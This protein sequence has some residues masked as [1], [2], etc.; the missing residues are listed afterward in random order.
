[1][2]VRTVQFGDGYSQAI[3]D[4]LNIKTQNW[5]LTFEGGLAY[6][7]PIRDFL[8][9]HAGSKS[10]TWIPPGE[11]SPLYFRASEWT[12]TS[13]GGGVYQITVEFK[14]VFHT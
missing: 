12:M 6:V 9:R 10:F 1:M 7:K 13:V 8:D 2:R 14:Q 4:G 3:P 5:P 11:L